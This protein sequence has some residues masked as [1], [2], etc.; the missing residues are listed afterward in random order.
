MVSFNEGLWIEEA[1]ESFEILAASGR[2]STS[3]AVRTRDKLGRNR[4]AEA[5]DVRLADVS[6]YTTALIYPWV[7]PPLFWVYGRLRVRMLLA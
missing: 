6:G 3:S 4:Q 1:A 5:G 7:L 2:P